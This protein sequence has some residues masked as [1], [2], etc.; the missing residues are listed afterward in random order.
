[1]LGGVA[2]DP[3][4]P[5]SG[6]LLRS[7]PVERLFGRWRELDF[8]FLPHPLPA[9]ILPRPVDLTLS[10]GSF[11]R[12][13]LEQ[14]RAYARKAFELDSTYLYSLA[15]PGT[16][17]EA[18]RSNLRAAIEAWYW[19]HEIQLWPL[20][21]GPTAGRPEARPGQQETWGDCSHLIGWKRL[22]A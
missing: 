22:R 9:T 13:P 16:S 1:V 7:E 12:M 20:G 11:P 3:V 2:P 19:P 17:S 5:G 15:R 10:L 14:V 8:I 4:P 21:R 18:D 6:W